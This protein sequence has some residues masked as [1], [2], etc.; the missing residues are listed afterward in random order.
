MIANPCFAL[1]A[2]SMVPYFRLIFDS[3]NWRAKDAL[4]ANLTA[5][6]A[7]RYN[8][9]AGQGMRSGLGASPL[10]TNTGAAS[11]RRALASKQATGGSIT[12]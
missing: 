3:E 8:T 4:R 7:R 1:W 9:A 12:A 2:C 6:P 10:C 11:K 5:E